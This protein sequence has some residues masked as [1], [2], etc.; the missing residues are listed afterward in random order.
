M[1]THLATKVSSSSL[2]YRTRGAVK[3]ISCSL[4]NSKP[5]ETLARAKLSN[6]LAKQGSETDWQ[7][8]NYKKKSVKSATKALKTST[9]HGKEK[10]TVNTSSIL[11]HIDSGPRSSAPIC[12]FS[13]D[14][15]IAVTL[16]PKAAGPTLWDIVD[17]AKQAVDPLAEIMGTL[18]PFNRPSFE[19]AKPSD[20]SRF[21]QTHGYGFC[22]YLALEQLSRKTSTLYHP[23]CLDLARADNRLK[24]TKFYEGQRNIYENSNAEINTTNVINYLYND[25]TTISCNSNL[26]LSSDHIYKT[27]L[28][29]EYTLFSDNKILGKPYIS[30]NMTTATDNEYNKIGTKIVFKIDEIIK[31]I[32]VVTH[33]QCQ[34]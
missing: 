28:N 22:G 13:M 30:I 8:I 3:A 33:I 7:K 29:Y 19:F 18:R 10:P 25:P 26:Y 9:T 1:N 16:D 14:Q 24:L 6:K 27:K 4:I 32:E 11:D 20:T 34:S 5:P 21:S 12:G 2:K 23:T 31:A 17:K 15:S